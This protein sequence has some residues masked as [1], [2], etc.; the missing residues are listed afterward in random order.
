[1]NANLPITILWTVTIPAELVALFGIQSFTCFGLQKG[2]VFTVMADHAIIVR[3]PGT[4]VD[5]EVCVFVGNDR[6][7][8][9]IPVQFIR[10]LLGMAGFA[11]QSRED[12]V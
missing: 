12:S 5:G 9:I 10:S 7:S 3:A 6:V 4:M 2:E 8:V 1:M 11:I